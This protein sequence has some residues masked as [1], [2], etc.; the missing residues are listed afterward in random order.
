MSP[1][2]PFCNNHALNSPAAR[3]NITK[4][5]DRH[6]AAGDPFAADPL[7]GDDAQLSSG[8]GSHHHD[9]AIGGILPRLGD[10]F[11]P[12]AFRERFEDK[13]R[14]REYLADETGA[15]ICGQPLALANAL[16]KR[17]AE[18]DKRKTR[19]ESQ[20]AEVRTQK[21]QG[22]KEIQGLLD[23]SPFGKDAKI[24]MNKDL[25]HLRS[26]IMTEPV[27]AMIGESHG[28][29]AARDAKIPL[30]RFGFPIFDRVNKHR[31]PV[32]GY[33]GAINMLSEICNKFLDI[34]DETCDDP[35]FE[36]MR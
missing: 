3:A 33:Q 31:S 32:I 25:W 2:C 8:P 34:T 9:L 26:L 29:F 28:K 17:K 1:V 24:Y 11:D 15:R 13:G 22:E 6:V 23:A 19:F 7:I 35:H 16:R 27:D 18:L 14:F 5:E 4:C 12:A 36:L 21:K 30:F 20:L 10:L